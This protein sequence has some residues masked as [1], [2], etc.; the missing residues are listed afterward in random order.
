M[1]VYLH[2]H[3]P[4]VHDARSF[5]LYKAISWPFKPNITSDLFTY[6]Q[7]EK[8]YLAVNPATRAHMLLS[9]DDLHGCLADKALH[10]CHPAVEVITDQQSCAYAL[11]TSPVKEVRRL[12]APHYTLTPKARYLGLRH[13]RDWVFSLPHF[14]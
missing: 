14:P 2:I 5:V 7:T 8:P 12:C 1:T 11:L 4:L 6:Y 13:G 10:I 3:I 9:A